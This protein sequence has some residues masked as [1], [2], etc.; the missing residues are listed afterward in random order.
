MQSRENASSASFL[1]VPQRW[2]SQGWGHDV[3]M[4]VSETVLREAATMQVRRNSLQL[5][6]KSGRGWGWGPA[7]RSPPHPPSLSPADMA[8]ASGC[9]SPGSPE[10]SS[11]VFSVFSGSLSQPLEVDMRDRTGFKQLSINTL[12]LRMR[13]TGLVTQRKCSLPHAW[14]EFFYSVHAQSHLH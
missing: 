12:P 9:P 5:W 4:A 1:T 7:S 13:C 2:V 6:L 14:A 11:K 3:T 10:V 8:E